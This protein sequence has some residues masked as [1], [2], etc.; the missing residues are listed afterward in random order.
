[1]LL[2]VMQWCAWH[3][4]IVARKII[5][6]KEANSGTYASVELITGESQPLNKVEVDE[7]KEERKSLAAAESKMGDSTILPRT[8][9]G[10]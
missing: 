2:F 1:M 5:T 3:V 10:V 8:S 9:D 7:L 4:K 6:L